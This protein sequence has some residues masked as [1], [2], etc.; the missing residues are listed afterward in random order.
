MGRTTLRTLVALAC[1][2]AVALGQ[3]ERPG[4]AERA[5]AVQ[6]PAPLIRSV[7]PSPPELEP[8][9]RPYAVKISFD[10]PKTTYNILG[11]AVTCSPARASTRVISTEQAFSPQ[12]AAGNSVVFT[13]LRPNWPYR[14]TMVASARDPS[15]N[16]LTSLRRSATSPESPVFTTNSTEGVILAPAASSP[17][18]EAATEPEQREQPAP[19]GARRQPVRNSLD[20][21]Q[22]TIN[23]PNPEGSGAPVP[24]LILKVTPGDTSVDINF[25]PAIGAR[26]ISNYIAN[27]RPTEGLRGAVE[28]ILPV[29]SEGKPSVLVVNGLTKGR[30]YTCTLTARSVNPAASLFTQRFQDSKPSEPSRAFA[31]SAAEGSGDAAA[32]AQQAEPEQPAAAGEEGAQQPGAAKPQG[33]Q[34]PNPFIDPAKLPAVTAANGQSEF[35]VTF[36]SGEGDSASVQFDPLAGATGYVLS[37]QSGGGQ[38]FAVELPATATEG[39]VEGL[40]A[41]T[42]TCTVTAKLEG[43]EERQSSVNVEIS[44]GSGRP[45]GQFATPREPAP[46]APQVQAPAIKAMAGTTPASGALGLAVPA[47]S[48]VVCGLLAAFVAV[49]L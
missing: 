35:G 30:Q 11:Y 37:C 18:A 27:C 20:V 43:G 2:A 49:A 44:G 26:P 4:R 22:A 34:E 9:Q 16:L 33:A 32:K 3:S 10:P 48:A 24:P 47:L 17:A 14:C 28:Q 15:V 1:L 46:Q 38:P 29:P 12:Q 36:V 42:Y 6:V 13:G 7:E 40:Q 5:T 25:A 21:L 45:V 41:G 31:P 39:R 23:G 19:A 8:R